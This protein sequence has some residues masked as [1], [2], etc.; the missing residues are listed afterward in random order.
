MAK[1]D[2]SIKNL[3]LYCLDY[4]KL[5]TPSLSGAVTKTDLLSVDI[6]D[7]RP[8]LL[9]NSEDIIALP[10][11]L[12]I[13]DT[14]LENAENT[15]TPSEMKS[16]KSEELDNDI[17]NQ[18]ILYK[19]AVA[20]QLED[21]NRKYQTA[22]YTKQ[23][24][25]EFGFLGFEAKTNIEEII[26]KELRPIFSIP[27]KIL[28]ADKNGKRY[29]SLELI[30]DKVS[31]NLSFLNKYLPTNYY[32][33]LFKFIAI[34]EGENKT[35]LPLEGKFLDELWSKVMHYL[36][37]INA[38]NI[39]KELSFDQSILS[40]KPYTNYFLTQD[41]LSLGEIDEEILKETSLDAWISEE[42]MSINQNTSDDGSSNVFFPFPYDKYQLKVLGILDNKSAIV[43]GPPGTGKSQTISNILCHLAAEG[44]RVLF[45]SQKDQAIRG[46]KDKLKSLDIPFLFGY[47]PDRNSN[48]H[49]KNDETDSA[50]QTL[51]ALSNEWKKQEEHNPISQLKIL[52]NIQPTFS[53]AIENE[54][55]LYKPYE[56]LAK[57]ENY[58]FDDFNITLDWWIKYKKC[59]E[60]IK[61]IQEFI[62]NY[63][64]YD[65]DY[66]NDKENYYN[67]LQI[68][69]LNTHSHIKGV[70]DI[71]NKAAHDRD[72]LIRF[73]KDI[74]LKH[75][76]NQITETLPKEL[77]DEITALIFSKE[78]KSVRLNH[79]IRIHKYFVYKLQKSL[80]HTYVSNRSALIDEASIDE[81]NLF[82]LEELVQQ[83]NAEDVIKNIL[84][85]KELKLIISN[86]EK[87]DL[88]TLRSQ[89]EREKSKYKASTRDYIHN[90]LLQKMLSIRLQKRPRAILERIAK[91]LSKNKRA[92]KT[93]DRLKSDPENFET[94]SSAIPIWMM[95]FDDASRILPMQ[96][97]LFDYVIIDEASQCNIAYALPV[98]F[99]SKHTLF[100]GDSL[101][102]RDTTILFK[103]NEQLN[104]IALKHGI[105]DEYQIKATEDTV[106]SV[107]DIATL[108]G[109]Q[110]TGL[111]YHYRSPRE[112]IGFSNEYV[113]KKR[114][115]AMQV[116]NDNYLLYRNTGRVMVN[117]LITPR[118]DL[119]ISETT[120]IAEAYYIK[121]L[122]EELKSNEATKDK[123]IAILSFF[124]DQAELLRR[125]IEDESVKVSIIEGIQGDE[126]D[127]I[128]YS[129][130]I[131]SPDQKN[132][133]VSL[134]GEG[135]E[136]KRD[137]NE[138]RV[139]VAFSRARM[140]VHVVTS[141]PTQL[142]PEGIWIK[143]Y[144]EYI[145]RNGVISDKHTIDD[146]QFDSKFE[147]DVFEYLCEILPTKQYM[148]STQVKS[149]GFKIDLVVQDKKTSKKLAIE[150]DGPTHFENGDGQ[151]YVVNDFERQSILETAGWHFYRLA[152]HDWCDDKVTSKDDLQT[153]IQKFFNTETKQESTKK[154][155]SRI[156]SKSI[157]VDIP[158]ELI[159]TLKEKQETAKKRYPF[160]R[161]NNAEK[162]SNP[163][164]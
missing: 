88:N 118:K 138:G 77:Y 76:I 84:H 67:N 61:A 146:Q 117:H 59:S 96:A 15:V 52:S 46:V 109:F 111:Q 71:F 92:F 156:P 98:M 99:R 39:T 139:N 164:L 68:D 74:S 20:K 119:D 62:T 81:S 163:R 135:G 55:E 38:K 16:S 19:K 136:I 14:V 144:L 50:S 21:I 83:N 48:L 2:I 140:Q 29:Y 100:F 85:R 5:I 31:V 70:I 8:L 13:E 134:T 87:W 26:T 73:I 86:I 91:S 112:L 133:Y 154:A 44:K 153:Y 25:L 104:A 4:A 72:G 10:L 30:D 131:T 56:D 42:G 148:L 90:R 116:I 79:L 45:V 53:Q 161:K 106:K 1:Y 155:E 160:K 33:E 162:D 149:C 22:S 64:A 141:I 65:K 27:V 129:F 158:D 127:I 23:I 115:R 125:V 137:A 151:V 24:Q 6:L 130:V 128:I 35:I 54:R 47:I 43:E 7:C 97:N 122:V 107:M 18:E 41:L 58:N 32:D 69:E 152:Y 103:T 159:N 60:D 51:V 123:S 57:L 143:K 12:E 66:I 82:R 40:L 17:E 121:Q 28:K 120:N 142:W 145:D 157:S 80:L 95:S 113:Y 36:E 63:L 147:K 124:N 150:C 34:S 114:G 101:Q 93:F 9:A 75:K 94:M 11:N 132:R 126:K 89:I 105:P 108:A 37:L 110:K 49:T 3:A 102:M 78:S